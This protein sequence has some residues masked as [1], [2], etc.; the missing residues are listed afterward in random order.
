MTLDNLVGLG[1]EVITPD[2]GAI[3]KLLA[4]AARNRCDAGITQLSNESRFDTAYKAIMQMANAALQAKGY[5]TLTSKPGHHQTM[6]Q[7]L[8]R[9]S[10]AMWRIIP[11]IW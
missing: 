7:T 1:L 9:E 5:R 11:A 2:A 6:I 10:S 8:P 4:A 3:K